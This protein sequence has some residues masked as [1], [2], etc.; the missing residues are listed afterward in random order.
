[1]IGLLALLKPASV[2]GQVGGV[3]QAP[4]RAGFAQIKAASLSNRLWVFLAADH[5]VK[6]NVVI[7]QKTQ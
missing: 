1:M 4:L 3:K 7:L 5:A 6:R 2:M